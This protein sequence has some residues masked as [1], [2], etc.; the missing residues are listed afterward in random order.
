MMICGERCF[1]YEPC[2]IATTLV[3]VY[4]ETGLNVLAS[5]VSTTQ[6]LIS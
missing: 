1:T 4:L 6:Q 3:G 5:M 2:Y